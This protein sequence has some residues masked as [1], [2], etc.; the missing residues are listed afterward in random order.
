[1][2]FS[3]PLMPNP[4]FVNQETLAGS[5]RSWQR[6]TGFE[7]RSCYFLTEWFQL[8]VL[9]APVSSFLKRGYNSVCSHG[10]FWKLNKIKNIEPLKQ[11]PVC[12]RCWIHN[13]CCYYVREIHTQKHTHS[14]AHMYEHTL[15]PNRIIRVWIHYIFFKG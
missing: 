2:L 10:H 8:T 13:S 7:F 3:L 15:S 9:L 4:F 6:L 5:W 12:I 14:R 11:W 1:M